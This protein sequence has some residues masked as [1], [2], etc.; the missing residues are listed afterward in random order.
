M[1]SLEDRLKDLNRRINFE[2]EKNEAKKEEKKIEL[3]TSI[4]SASEVYP[5]GSGREFLGVSPLLPLGRF[6]GF[7]LKKNR[8]PFENLKKR[9]FYIIKALEAR[10]N[11]FIHPTVN[12][13]IDSELADPKV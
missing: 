13:K 7:Q 6:S 3:Y 4:E 9:N 12:L 5:Q 2:E 8:V 11:F 1:S 10:G